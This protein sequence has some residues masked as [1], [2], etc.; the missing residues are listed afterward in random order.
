[1]PFVI[2]GII[3]ASVGG[4]LSYANGWLCG[5]GLCP[6][7]PD[8]NGWTAVPQS[9][10]PAAVMT[11]LQAL[12]TAGATWQPYNYGPQLPPVGVTNVYGPEGGV[13]YYAM[14]VNGTTT[15]FYSHP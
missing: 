4:Y 11:G 8:A 2:I 9:A 10:V 7:V 12:V 15:Q 13:P 1:M 14:A 6:A 5:V 3:V